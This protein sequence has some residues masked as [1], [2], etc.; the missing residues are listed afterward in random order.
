MIKNNT[1]DLANKF[2]WYVF[3]FDVLVMIGGL[4]YVKKLF[5]LFGLRF[6]I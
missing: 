2:S 1:E 3:I 5:T 4:L 6:L